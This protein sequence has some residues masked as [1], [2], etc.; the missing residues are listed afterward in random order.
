MFL[1][2]SKAMLMLFISVN[3]NN[4][5]FFLKHVV[6]CKKFCSYS[7]VKSLVLEELN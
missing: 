4:H 2:L 7:F 5:L 6:N 1:C 3:E